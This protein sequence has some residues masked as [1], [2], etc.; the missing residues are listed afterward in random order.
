MRVISPVVTL[1]VHV[2]VFTFRALTH[3]DYSG[4]LQH[5]ALLLTNTHYQPPYLAHLRKHK[6]LLSLERLDVL[7][8]KTN[9]NSLEDNCL[10]GRR[11]CKGSLNELIRQVDERH[12]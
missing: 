9:P 8:F 4:L 7:I 12:T 1:H 2:H 3:Q 5:I 11:K 6:V 10:I